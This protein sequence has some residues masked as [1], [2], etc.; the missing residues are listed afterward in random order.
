MESFLVVLKYALYSLHV[1]V[2][3]VMI[4]AI[5]LQAGRSAGI[6]TALG[7]GGSQT[8]F[9]ASGG[10]G[11][12]AKFT[13][14]AAFTFMLT[15]IGLAKLST[16][17]ESRFEAKVKAQQEK[18]DKGK[19]EEVDLDELGVSVM[20]EGEEAGGGDLE[21]APAEEGGEEPAVEEVGGQEPAPPAEE[22]P[23]EEVP[24]EEAPAEEAPVEEAPAEEAPAEPVQPAAGESGG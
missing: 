23:A 15:S 9:G 16:P 22:V 3:I 24:A 14:I 4:L 20:P 12:L 17:S 5:L 11:F 7:G 19:G 1:V 10:Q 21:P 18:L 2:C 6:G 13:T 8:L